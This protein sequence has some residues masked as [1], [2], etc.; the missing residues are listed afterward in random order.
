MADEFDRYAVYWVPKRADPLA[1][2]GIAWTGWCAEQGEPRPRG[3]FANLSLDIPAITRKVARHGFHAVIRAPFRLGAGRSRFSLEHVLDTLA[4]VCVA[5]TLPPL[6]LAVVEGS[7]A[8]VPDQPC[9]GLGDLVV[10]IDSAIGPLDAA[11]RRSRVGSGSN[12]TRAKVNGDCGADVVDPVIQLPAAEFHRFHMPLTDPLSVEMAFRV[13]AELKPMLEPMMDLPRRLHH[14]AL[15][16]DPGGG[17]PL[18]VLQRYELRDEPAR[19][20]TVA[21]PCS[22]PHVLT[23]SFG[24]A[25]APSEAV[26]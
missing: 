24:D 19:R 26:V 20:A 14:I 21:L 3:V 13:K 1:R 2:F 16:G 6:R 5:Q 22:G 8:L 10:Q 9:A 11:E 17:R 15:M 7:V 12:G 25:M 18:R 23:P 4:E